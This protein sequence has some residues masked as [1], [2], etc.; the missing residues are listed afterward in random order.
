[1]ASLKDSPQ[2]YHRVLQRIPPRATP[3]FSDEGMQERVWGRRWGA[4][5]DVGTLKTVLLHR[6]GDEIDVMVNGGHYDPE[7]EAIID[8]DEQWYFRSDKAPSLAKMQA[9]HDA[10]AD[11]LRVNGVEVVYMDGGPRDPNSMFTRDMGMVVDGGIIISRMG[12]VGKPYGTGRRGEELYLTR[13]VAELGMPIYR[14]IAGEGLMEGG[15]FCLLDEKHA[16]IGMSFRGNTTGADQVEEVLNLLGIE[17]IRVPLPGFAMHLDGGIVMVD[18][19]KA[20]VNVERL[21]YWFIDRLAELG[22]EMIFADY[23]DVGYAVNV[24]T[25]RP[26]VVIMDQR[27]TWTRE[28]LE[29]RGVTVLPVCWE[30][31]TKHGGGVHCSSLPLVRERD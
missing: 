12:P 16:A 30:E 24:L 23:R 4:R 25:I 19:G 1:M 20:V 31:C 11:L 28:S 7:I 15:S 26:G 9:E 29:K 5:T 2:Y 10:F 8:D 6:P 22:I 13:K 3:S 17:L 14:T 27:G 21:P 18:H